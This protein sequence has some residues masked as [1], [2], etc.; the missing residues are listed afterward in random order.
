MRCTVSGLSGCARLRSRSES[1]MNIFSGSL[2]TGLR[3]SANNASITSSGS[4]QFTAALLSFASYLPLGFFSNSSR[5]VSSSPG[6]WGFPSAPMCSRVV[7]SIIS[8]L[9]RNTGRAGPGV[10]T[11][12]RT[13]EYRRFMR[14]GSVR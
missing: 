10:V 3:H 7:S 14:A 1:A 6:M 9:E 2:S 11:L 5:Q 13:A 8:V 12:P 4:F